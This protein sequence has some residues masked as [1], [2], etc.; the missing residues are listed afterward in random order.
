MRKLASEL[1]DFYDDPEHVIFKQ[2]FPDPEVLPDFIKAAKLLT[3][4]ERRALPDDLFALVV[5]EDDGKLRKFARTDKANTALSVVY[6]LDGGAAKLSDEL[7]KTAAESL[8]EGCGWYD[9]EAP[10]VLQKIA[11]GEIDEGVTKI[12]G[13]GAMA[14]IK[15]MAMPSQDKYPLDSYRDAQSSVR[16]FEKYAS[17]LSPRGRREFA[18]NASK[19]AEELGIPVTQDM[20]IYAS[21]TMADKNKIARQIQLRIDRAPKPDQRRYAT[22]YEKIASVPAGVAAEALALLDE[23][24][25]LDV[26]W[27]GILMDPY[28]TVLEI[29]KEASYAFHDTHGS[30]TDEDIKDLANR[31]QKSIEQAFDK[32]FYK[33]FKGDPV[34]VFKSLPLPEKRT[35]IRLRASSD[36]S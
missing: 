27:D 6:F 28:Q 19:R 11:K 34:T 13:V 7:A 33:T 1:L 2:R 32:D 36:F 21:E 3:P 10:E 23:E 30:V 12:A 4:E 31:Q 35:L 17:K 5:D 15:H 29:E 25:G 20:Q 18:T 8:I 22:F 24:A 26:H 9:L 14:E 16:F